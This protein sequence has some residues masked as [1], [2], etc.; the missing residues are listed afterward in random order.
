M[1]YTWPNVAKRYNN[2]KIKLTGPRWT[3]EITFPD[4]SY[5]IGQLQEIIFNEQVKHDSTIR[6]TDPHLC[7]YVNK[8]TNRI[9]VK[10]DR[11][12]SIDFMSDEMMKLVGSDKRVVAGAYQ[13]DLPLVPHLEQVDV[14]NVHCNMVDNESQIDRQLWY[15]FTPSSSYGSLLTK[16]PSVSL[17]CKTLPSKFREVHV[18]L[19][20]QDNRDLYVEDNINIMLI[21]RDM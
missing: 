16:E 3:K 15:Y 4:G 11:G 6:E 10:L 7:L 13:K 2:N 20:D 5:S 21:F 18:W 14:V 12:Y 1:Y 17:F 8:I 19:T 9:I